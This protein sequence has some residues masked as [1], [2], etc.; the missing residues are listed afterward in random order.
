[1]E[2][3]QTVGGEHDTN[4]TFS[5]HTEILMGKYDYRNCPRVYNDKKQYTGQ[6]VYV[7]NMLISPK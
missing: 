2:I 3:V 4:R 1:M 5:E 6:Y 7:G